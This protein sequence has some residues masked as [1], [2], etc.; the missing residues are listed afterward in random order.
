VESRLA[1]GLLE[2]VEGREIGQLQ[3]F[4]KD[5]GGLDATVSEEQVAL[6]LGQ[7]TPITSHLTPR[8]IQSRQPGPSNIFRN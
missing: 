4:E 1:L 7:G 5:Q 2:Q 8:A 6:E 3:A